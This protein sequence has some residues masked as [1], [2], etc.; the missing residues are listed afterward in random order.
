MEDLDIRRT[1]NFNYIKTKFSTC[2]EE[3]NYLSDRGHIGT[4]R[5]PKTRKIPNIASRIEKNNALGHYFFIKV[6]LHFN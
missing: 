5:K 4:C 2:K 3:K 6:K 1:V